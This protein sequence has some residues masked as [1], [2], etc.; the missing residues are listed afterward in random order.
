MKVSVSLIFAGLTAAVGLM[1]ANP[2]L[3][4]PPFGEISQCAWPIELS[5]EGYGNILAPENQARYWLVPFDSTYDTMKI[6]GASLN[7]RYF[8]FVVYDTATK[9]PKLKWEVTAVEGHKYDDILARN[10]DQSSYTLCVTRNNAQCRNV[11]SVNNN[12]AWVMLRIY[13]PGADKA[14]GGQALMGGRP[15]PA[16]TLLSG[17]NSQ[18]L[19]ACPLSK[20]VSSS[21]KPRP[22]IPPPPSP[23]YYYA[24]SVNKLDAIRAFVDI[25]FP[26]PLD[27]YTPRDWDQ[28]AGDRLWFAP[29]KEPPVLLMPNPDN[30]YIAMQPGPYQPGRVIVI[31]GKAP[32]FGHDD[33]AQVRFWSLCNYDLVLPAP[34]VGCVTDDQAT[35]AQDG[36]YTIVVS[37]DLLRPD[38]LPAGVNWIQWGDEQYPKL[39]FLRHLI[40][41][42]RNDTNYTKQDIPFAQ[43][44]QWVVEGCPGKCAHPEATI[45]FNLPYAPPRADFDAAGPSAQQIMGDYYPRAAWCDQAAFVN[46]GWQACIK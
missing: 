3:A 1:A 2:V 17:R 25:L 20:Q 5:P 11:I 37:D 44:I 43:A 34:L 29:P 15:L 32:R 28:K 24:R 21:D 7:A 30:K 36:S 41:V 26:S 42:A 31:H 40:P 14:L 9:D 33:S 16:I 12:P 38:W 39:I 10:S 6:E 45:N 27:I 4:K 23:V 35:L 19:Q 22:I 13:A 18:T 46:G 8:S